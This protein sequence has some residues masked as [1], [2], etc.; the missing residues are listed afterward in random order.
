MSEP[1]EPLICSANIKSNEWEVFGTNP[2]N[3]LRFMTLVDPN[4]NVPPTTIESK[5]LA[6]SSSASIV[7]S[8]IRSFEKVSCPAEFPGLIVAAEAILTA[9]DSV[10][11]PL[12]LLQTA[13]VL[14]KKY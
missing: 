10:P 9:P 1:N 2:L 7:P 12:R 8:N 6:L 13:E 3:K 5:L 11:F 14:R 4:V